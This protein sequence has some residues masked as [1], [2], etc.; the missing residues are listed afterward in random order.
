MRTETAVAN[1][2]WTPD[3]TQPLP[4]PP[5]YPDA[6]AGLVTVADAVGNV[7]QDTYDDPA[8]PVAEPVEP[9]PERSRALIEAVL[10]AEEAPSGPPVALPP[11]PGV[12]TT[13]PP[14]GMVAAPERGSAAKRMRQAL[15]GSG[16]DVESW[17][18]ALRQRREQMANRSK[19]GQNGSSS[20]SSLGGVVFALIILLVFLAIAVQVISGVASSVSELFN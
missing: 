15:S 2:S 17:R 19:G 8:V 4:P 6:L 10:A 16:Q 20:G 13:G 9:D 11:P 3:G 1:V 7:Q 12:A 5:L 14:P 18:E